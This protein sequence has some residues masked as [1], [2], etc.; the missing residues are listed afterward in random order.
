MLAPLRGGSDY[1]NPVR[2]PRSR[3]RGRTTRRR[4][5]RHYHATWKPVDSR[6]RSD[7]TCRRLDSH[8]QRRLRPLHAEARPLRLRPDPC[9]VGLAPADPLSRLRQASSAN[10]AAHQ[11]TPRPTHPALRD[12][13][14]NGSPPTWRRCPSSSSSS[15][16]TATPTYI[17]TKITDDMRDTRFAVG[18]RVT[19]WNSI[20]FARAVDLYAET[21]TGGRPDAR[22]ARALETLTQRPSST[23][24]PRTNSGSTSATEPP[25]IHADELDRTIRF[26]WRAIEPAKAITADDL[27]RAAD[28]TCDRRHQRSGP[29]RPQAAL[30]YRALGTR[31]THQPTSRQSRRL[32]RH[33]VLRRHLRP[34][35]QDQPRHVRLSPT[36]DLRRG[37]H[38]RFV[39]AV[40]DLLRQI[41]RKGLIIDLR[42]NPGGVID[43]A[44]HLLQLFTKNRIEPTRFACE[45]RPRWCSWPKPTATAP[46]SRTGPARPGRYE[47]GEEFSQHLP[48]SDPD[49]SRRTKRVQGSSRRRRR[50]PTRSRAAT[51]SRPASSTMASA[52]SSRS[53]MPPAPA[54]PTCGQA[55]TSNTSTTPP[56]ARYRPSRPASA[57]PSRCDE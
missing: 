26:E 43:T 54:A 27:D 39:E 4:R 40:A 41:P 2:R 13:A 18:A 5:R 22:R 32:D 24:R 57:S 7:T 38:R 35:D 15:G 56:T 42:S 23:S 17:V 37:T 48:I 12:A 10:Y 53:A 6:S 50:T 30:R 33:D 29:P 20:P 34:P 55:T 44:E 16:R 21:L 25:R 49:A 52:R 11:P 14:D 51:S 3:A 8:V 31:P 46:T 47:L 36:V 9:A 19:T 28:P 45:P 1:G